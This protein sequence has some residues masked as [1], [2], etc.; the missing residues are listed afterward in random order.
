MAARNKNVRREWILFGLHCGKLGL[1]ITYRCSE[2]FQCIVKAG[3]THYCS[4]EH[5]CC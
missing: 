1:D 4:H 3:R 2:S 5:I